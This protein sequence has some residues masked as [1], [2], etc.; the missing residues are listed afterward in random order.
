MKGNEVLI[1]VFGDVCPTKDTQKAIE[2]GDNFS[3]LGNCQ[4]L[5]DK[6][7]FSL[8]NVEFPIIDNGVPALK[9]GPVFSSKTSSIDFF[10]NAGF[11]LLSLANNHIK[12]CGN[13]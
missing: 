13:R 7:D 8:C 5:L 6:S 9:T 11:D 1:S 12:D 4:T 10:T 2:S 3:V